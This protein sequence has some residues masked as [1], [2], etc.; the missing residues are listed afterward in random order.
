[1]KS[2]RYSS[3]LAMLFG[4]ILITGCVEKIDVEKETAAIM[5]VHNNQRV[6]HFE[7]KIDGTY[8]MFTDDLIM[9]NRGIISSPTEEEFVARRTAYFGAVEFEKWDDITPPVIRFSDDYSMAYTVVNK[10]VVVTYDGENGEKVRG[11]TI[12][13]W[14][15]IYKKVDGEWKIDAVASTNQPDVEEIIEGG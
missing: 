14:I 8:A 3:L 6:T 4:A 13:S 11:T 9:V 1:M 7:E 2:I 12:F 15:A 5:A 10:E